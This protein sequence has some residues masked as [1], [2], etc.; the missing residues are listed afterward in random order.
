MTGII[1][2]TDRESSVSW[3]GCDSLGSNNYTKSIESPAKAFRN[4]Q[5]RNVLMGGTTSFRHL[6]LLKYA[7][8][9]FDGIDVYRKPT[10][11]PES[12]RPHGKWVKEPF[13]SRC[14][15]TNCKSVFPEWIRVYNYCPLCGARMMEEE[16]AKFI[17]T[18]GEMMKNETK[19][20]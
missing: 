7:E 4:E 2:F 13:S 8:D 11:D 5:I 10:I 18:F 9:L 19:V 3:I 20:D 15:C 16:A 14:V 6:D 17:Q 1:G 12:L